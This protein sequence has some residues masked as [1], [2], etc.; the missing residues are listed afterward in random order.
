MA[1]DSRIEAFTY[2]KFA[3]VDGSQGGSIVPA[4]AA[5]VDA[6]TARRLGGAKLLPRD[7]RKYVKFW[8]RAAAAP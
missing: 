7:E 1:G 3:D 4:S 6:V 8:T 2:E 5:D